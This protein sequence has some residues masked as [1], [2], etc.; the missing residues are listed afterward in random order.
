MEEKLLNNSDFHEEQV[1]GADQI[2]EEPDGRLSVVVGRTNY[3]V[4]VHFCKNTKQTYDDRAKRLMLESL[5]NGD[6]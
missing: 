4:G 3:L 6:F 5:K 2:P 1:E